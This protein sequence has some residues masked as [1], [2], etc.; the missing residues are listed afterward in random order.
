MVELPTGRMKTREGT[1]VDADDLMSE[2]IQ[3]ARN[4][5][6]D[7]GEITALTHEEQEDILRK[8]GLAALKFFIIKV[9]P[10]KRMIFD[11]KES[12]DMQGQTG[13]YVQNA[14]VRIQS[15]KR[16]A[17][18]DILSAPAGELAKILGWSNFFASTIALSIPGMLLLFVVA[19]WSEKPSGDAL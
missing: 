1:V 4:M 14:Y 8:I 6:A 5:S 18:N 11:P 9:Q 19:P 10:K 15:V 2:V 7:R 3:E 12:V 17:G 16:K 13:P